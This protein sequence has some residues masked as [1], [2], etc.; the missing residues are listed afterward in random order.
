MNQHH[1]STF[2]Y[3]TVHPSL[4]PS[5]VPDRTVSSDCSQQTSNSHQQASVINDHQHIY[6]TCHHHSYSS[7]DKNPH[8][9]NHNSNLIHVNEISKSI[10]QWYDISKTTENNMIQS[11]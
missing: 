7:I 11:K 2:R 4:L 6:K 3:R 5:P 1:T 10:D 9:N 8:R